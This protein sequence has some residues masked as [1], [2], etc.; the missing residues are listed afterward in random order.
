MMTAWTQAILSK[1]ISPMAAFVING[2][3]RKD[4]QAKAVNYKRE[5][6]EAIAKA[7]DVTI[8][9]VCEMDSVE[10]FDLALL[11]EGGTND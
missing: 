10:I 9:E 7:F 8:E 3:W 5:Q 11:I 1:R 2:T 4:L 6:V